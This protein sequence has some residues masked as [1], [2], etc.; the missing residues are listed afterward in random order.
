MDKKTV[1]LE[2]AAIDQ[3]ELS[4]ILEKVS[5][6]RLLMFFPM[7]Y[8]PGKNLAALIKR[9]MAVDDMLNSLPFAQ[10][11]TAPGAL[12]VIRVFIKRAYLHGGSFITQDSVCLF[13][14]LCLKVLLAHL[15]MLG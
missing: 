1:S 2:N 13:H 14:T 5:T 3:L 15:I 9:A 4:S 10:S 8:F 7:E 12:I 11:L 6:Y